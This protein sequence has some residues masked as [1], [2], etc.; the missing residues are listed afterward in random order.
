MSKFALC[1]NQNSVH[2]VRVLIYILIIR[3]IWNSNFENKQYEEH[4]EDFLKYI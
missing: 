1:L 2:H 4:I 3:C